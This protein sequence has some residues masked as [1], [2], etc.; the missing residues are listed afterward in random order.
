MRTTR[1]ALL[2]ALAALLLSAAFL[3]APVR[4]QDEDVSDED[5]YEDEERAFLLVKKSVVE[6]AVVQGRN[7]TVRLELFNVGAT[8]ALNVKI[9]ELPLPEQIQL[10]SGSLTGEIARI[11]SGGV[12]TWEYVAAS[13]SAGHFI[14]PPAE[15]TYQAEADADSIQSAKS[16][17][18]A[19]AILSPAQQNI[20][21]ALKAGSYV[22]LGMLNTMGDWSNAAIAVG[23]LALI[24]GGNWAYSKAV[25]SSADRRRQKALEELEGKSD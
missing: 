13:T 4:A 19:C 24:L 18:F 21:L 3:A 2:A 14:A 5:D 15:V 6:D 9:E 23:A 8:S 11:G 7:F 16:T 1:A 25:Q 20:N 22:S 17:I 10:L 12:A